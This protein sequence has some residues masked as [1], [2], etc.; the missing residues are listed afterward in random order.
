M[1]EF[2]YPVTEI[3]HSL[4]GEGLNV[5]RSAWFIRLGGCNLDCKTVIDGKEYKCDEPLKHDIRNWK[6]STISQI[7]EQLI[8]PS[9]L[10]VITGGEPTLWDLD[11]L[12]L[13]LKEHTKNWHGDFYPIQDSDLFLYELKSPLICLETN[14]TRPLPTEVDFVCVSPKPEHHGLKENA[15]V[16]DS[17]LQRANEIKIVVGWTKEEDILPLIQR[18]KSLNPK[19]TIFLSPLTQFPGNTLIPET[20]EL[21][22]NLVKKYVGYKVRLSLQ[23]HKWINIR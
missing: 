6:N 23:T 1:K 15:K 19:C 10:I 20:V 17:S 5:G 13:A 11:P 8:T 3:F 22:V 4:Q 9:E 7:C 21:A 12:I 16:L 2:T 18:Y 14:G